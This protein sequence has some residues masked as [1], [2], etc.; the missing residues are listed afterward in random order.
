MDNLNFK[1][2]ILVFTYT[3]GTT[4][5]VYLFLAFIIGNFQLSD[6]GVTYKNILGFGFF[7]S[8]ILSFLF[9][10]KYEEDFNEDF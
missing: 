5:F 6:W 7:V 10:S 3:F 8:L 9:S 1:D 4:F 2:T